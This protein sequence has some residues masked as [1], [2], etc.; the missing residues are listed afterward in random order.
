MGFYWLRYRR[1]IRAYRRSTRRQ[2]GFYNLPAGTLEVHEDFTE[3]ITREAK[4]ETGA[5]ITLEH[6][7]G[8]YQT[9]IMWCL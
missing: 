9:A 3:C 8:V 4:E 7:V 5:D 6:F 1:Q 2:V